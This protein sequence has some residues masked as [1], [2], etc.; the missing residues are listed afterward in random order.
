MWLL[1]QRRR[2]VVDLRDEVL[3]AC[4]SWLLSSPL[5]SPAAPEIFFRSIHRL[6]ARL[7]LKAI[8]SDLK[9]ISG[10]AGDLE[11]DDK[12]QLQQAN[13]DFVTQINNIASSAGQ[14]RH[15]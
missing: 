15:R 5:R 2:D 9:K 13:K 4:W 10:A 1:T 14:R 7:D 12:S 3:V 6:Q 8:D 11:G